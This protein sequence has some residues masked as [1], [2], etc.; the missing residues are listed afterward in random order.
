[1]M[2]LDFFITQGF[3]PQTLDF[4]KRKDLRLKV[5]PY[6]FIDG[7]I[8]RINYDG[9]FLR[10]LKKEESDNILLELHSGP[11]WGHYSRNTIAHNILRVVYYW[12]TLFKDAYDFSRKCEAFQICAHKVKKYTFPLHPVTI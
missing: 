2:K 5:V 4:N 6:Q 7:M 8:F 12:P 10:C 3:S 11:A 9:I 1:M